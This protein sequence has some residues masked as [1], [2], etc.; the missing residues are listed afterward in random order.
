VHGLTAQIA[1]ILAVVLAASATVLALTRRTAGSFF[2]AG[3][4]WTGF[5]IGLSAV[6]GIGV[7]ITD[8]VPGDPLHIVYGVLAVGVVPGAAVVAGGRSDRR[9]TVV[10]AIAGIVLVIIVLRLFQTGG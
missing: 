6:I 5:V 4:L 1:L 3:T 8:H 9:A 2:V 10:W 7:A